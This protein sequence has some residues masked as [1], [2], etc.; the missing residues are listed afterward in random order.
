MINNR[1]P[2]E[3]SFLD[4]LEELRWCLVRSLAAVMIFAVLAF[5]YK[6][7]IFDKILLAPKNPA[8]FTNRMLCLLGTELNLPH[9]CIKSKP[10]QLIN[11]DISGQFNT[12]LMVSFIAGFIIAFPYIFYEFWKFIKPAL[13][14]KE[15]K[16]A[17]GAIFYITFLFLLGILFGYYIIV[18]MSISFFGDYQVSN[19]VM[20]Q[21]NLGSYISMV[22]TTTLGCGIIFEIP[23]LIFFLSSIGILSPKFLIKYRRHAIVLILI[24]AAV[25]TPPDA[26]SQVIVALPL[27]MLYEV[28]IMISKKITKKREAESL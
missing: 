24:L 26:F 6:N 14:E 5:I 2:K 12:H 17:R 7:I 15:L 23:V 1:P 13:Y 8:F 20:N 21:I 3:M 19:S 11:L 27:I 4:H 16:K 25:I 10:F 18:P 22:T 28:G 9:L